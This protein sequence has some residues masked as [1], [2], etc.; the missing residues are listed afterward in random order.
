LLD[1][2][3]A[4]VDIEERRQQALRINERTAELVPMLPLARSVSLAAVSRRVRNHVPNYPLFY[5]YD[6]HPD[7]WAER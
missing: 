7:L 5:P 4:L 6:V 3:G 1:G 2:F